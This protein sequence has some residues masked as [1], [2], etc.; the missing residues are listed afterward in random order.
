MPVFQLNEES[1]AFPSSDLAEE[2]GLLAIGGDLKPAR[3]ISAYSQGIFPWYSEAEPILWW[4]PD[5]RF[6]IRTSEIHISRSM[7][8]FMN[9]NIYEF[10]V[11]SD[12]KSV[13]NYC[14]KVP[15]KD[16]DG[17]WITGEMISAYEELHKLGHALS[18]ETWYNNEL[19]GGI[20]GVLNEKY[21]AGESMFS[22]GDNA[23]KFA[24]IQACRYLQKRDV[25]IVDCQ[26]YTE[27]LEK[28][29][30]KHV[31]RNQFLNLIR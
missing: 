16:Q 29:G 11:N 6:I 22:L 30:G 18:F 5:P 8:R 21:F 10:K 25:E 20:Y 17:T 23:S 4:A 1:I 28:M 19:I 12:F 14:S 31:G 2:N 7:K 3:L 27:H 13:I 9:K 24:L 15:R 26:F